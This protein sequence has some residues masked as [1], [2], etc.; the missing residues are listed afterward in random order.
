M[1]FLGSCSATKRVTL[2]FRNQLLSVELHAVVDE[3]AIDVDRPCR[4]PA[5][6]RDTAQH[7]ATRETHS[8]SDGGGSELPRCVLFV[9][10]A[11]ANPMV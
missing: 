10:L 9:A 7:G 5:L 11:D 1:S 4:R 6:F 8:P 2:S 3:L